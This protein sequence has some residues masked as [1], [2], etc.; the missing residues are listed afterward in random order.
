MLKIECCPIVRAMKS[1]QLCTD[2]LPFALAQ[3]FSITENSPLCSALLISVLSH[4]RFCAFTYFLYL[5]I[6]KVL[7]SIYF[8]EVRLQMDFQLSNA[9]HQGKNGKKKC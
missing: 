6:S 3:N 9:L 4:S 7:S 5:C 2:L 8:S 1:G